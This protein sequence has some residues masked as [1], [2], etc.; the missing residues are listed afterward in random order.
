[1]LDGGKGHVSAVSPILAE[2]GLHTIPLYGLV[3]DKK[4]RTR[5]IATDGAEISITSAR[6]AF[7][8]LSKMQDEVH[9]FAV[10]MMRKRHKKSTFESALTKIPGIGDGRMRALMTHFRTQAALK[11]A[12]VD[13]LAA[14]KGMTR[15]AAKKL[16]EHLNS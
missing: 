3:K 5:A 9:R 13:E 12:S 11:A 6:G 16:H 1:L 7:T 15:P 10:T 2:M 8:L 14:V 4:H